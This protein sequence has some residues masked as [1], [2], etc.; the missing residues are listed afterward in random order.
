MHDSPRDTVLNSWSCTV[1]VLVGVRY[2]IH[3]S[4]NLKARMENTDYSSAFEVKEK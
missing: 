4:L 2:I 3:R 1:D